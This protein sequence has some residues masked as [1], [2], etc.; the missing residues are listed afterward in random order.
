MHLDQG[1][2]TESVESPVQYSQEDIQQRLNDYNQEQERLQELTEMRDLIGTEALGWV[3]KDDEIK[4]SRAVID[5][6]K[7]GL[8]ERSSTEMER[9]SILDH[10]PF[11]DH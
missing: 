6:I 5:A 3:P 9:T 7:A 11:D 4:W 1:Q 2:F 8:V 10:F